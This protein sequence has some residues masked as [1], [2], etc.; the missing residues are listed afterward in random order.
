MK[1]NDNDAPEQMEGF[2]ARLRGIESIIKQ[3]MQ[4]NTNLTLNFFLSS[5]GQHVERTDSAHVWMRKDDDMETQTFGSKGDADGAQH[6]DSIQTQYFGMPH[7]A[8]M[9]KKGNPV[10]HENNMPEVL[11]TKKAIRHCIALLMKERFSD[12]PLFNRQNHWQA[13]YRILVDKGY[14]RDSDFDG[15]DTFIRSVMPEEVNKPYK[16]ESVKQISKTDFALPF[17]RWHYDSQTSTTRKPYD[18]ML[19]IASRFKEFLEENMP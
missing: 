12:K 14:C 8:S 13:I 15:F 17:S 11:G 4:K 9:Q 5:V 18:R 6:V 16:K 1:N 3:A 19:L 10:W 2:N 7:D